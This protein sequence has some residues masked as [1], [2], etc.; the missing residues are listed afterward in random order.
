MFNLKEKRARI[1]LT[2]FLL[3][4]STSLLLFFL[5]LVIMALIIN[6]I[7]IR[8][9]TTLNLISIINYSVVFIGGVTA[10][11]TSKSRG[12]L[13]GLLVG[14]AYIL[15]L[16]VVGSFTTTPSFSGILVLKIVTLCLVST[17]GGI[18]GINII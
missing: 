8:N 1:K 17:L 5:G 9:S 12:W 16:I 18:I 6:V 4:L 3:G 10:A 14:L 13:N 7:N 11:Y 2:G 15:I